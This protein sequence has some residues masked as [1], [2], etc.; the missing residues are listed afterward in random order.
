MRVKARI[1]C[2]KGHFMNINTELLKAAA[3]ANKASQSLEKTALNMSG[4]WGN[5]KKA[6]TPSKR[7]QDTAAGVADNFANRAITYGK[8][9]AGRAYEGA[10]RFL[11]R[12]LGANQ[13]RYG[14]RQIRKGWGVDGPA[15]TNLIA[16]GIKNLAVGGAK[17]G[18]VYG[19]GLYGASKI[20]GGDPNQTAVNQLPNG[21]QMGYT[22]TDLQ[23]NP[24]A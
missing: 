1:V 24:Y 21:Y 16:S 2:I 18:L 20:L 19:G 13:A 4:I 5:I 22:Y 10:G 9:L 15:N 7:F 23:S 17:T 3:L 11:N 8:D 12:H 14:Y 6:I